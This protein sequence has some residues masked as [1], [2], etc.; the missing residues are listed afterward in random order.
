MA[1]ET[2][3][4]ARRDGASHPGALEA[5]SAA[6]TCRTISSAPNASDEDPIWRINAVARASPAENHVSSLP[7]SMLYLIGNETKKMK[8]DNQSIE[9]FLNPIINP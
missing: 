1:Y 8:K 5:A 9:N 4:N 7:L 3:G 2:S 6:S